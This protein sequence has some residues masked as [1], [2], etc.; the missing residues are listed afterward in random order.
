MRILPSLL[1]ATMLVAVQVGP[2]RADDEPRI[3]SDRFTIS[4]S[5]SVS[6]RRFSTLVAARA[7]AI[8]YALGAIL[9][10]AGAYI[11]IEFARAS[12]ASY[13][14]TYPAAY[15]PVRH[16]LTFRR[17]LLDSLNYNVTPWA[18]AYWPY[19]RTEGLRELIPAI[20]VIDNALWMAHLQEAAHRKGISWPHPEC[21]SLDAAK[22][23]G[24]EMLVAGAEASLHPPPMFN[25]NRLD[26]LWPESLREL[27]GRS[28]RR[29]DTAY[30]DV[31]R[32]GGLLLLRSL[33]AEFGLPRA[34]Q[35]IAQT[36]FHIEGDNVR[37]SALH[38]Q[39]Q[40]RL[41]LTVSAIN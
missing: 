20:E 7:E 22:R 25:S 30:R 39:E 36:P 27:R 21:S 37:V 35:Y 14:L 29:S 15:D 26:M 11:H 1:L 13:L 31:Q 2:C 23:L 10:G 3:I 28:W 19:Y 18:K 33:V 40:A 34:L 6:E 32:L 4:A 9:E 5:A 16:A 41:A 38:Y 24:C 17:A 12:D 8:D